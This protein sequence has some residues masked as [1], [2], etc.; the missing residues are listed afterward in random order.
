MPALKCQEISPMR[1]ETDSTNENTDLV[2]TDQSQA[3]NQTFLSSVMSGQFCE[4]AK[5]SPEYH[6]EWELEHR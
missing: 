5:S 3:M 2:T 6:E 4:C 1:R